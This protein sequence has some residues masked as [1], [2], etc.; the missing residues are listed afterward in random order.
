MAERVSLLIIGFV[1]TIVRTSN[2][3]GQVLMGAH[4][5]Q[6]QW[7]HAGPLCCVLETTNRASHRDQSLDVCFG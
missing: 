3:C 4:G 1:A 7:M 2:D 6:H 5:A